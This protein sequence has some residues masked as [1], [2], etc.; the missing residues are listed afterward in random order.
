MFKDRFYIFYPTILMS[1]FPLW[2]SLIRDYQRA[3]LSS[4]AGVPFIYGQ[5]D[6]HGVNYC[7][8]AV[9]FPHNIGLGAAND[10]DRDAKLEDFAFI[11]EK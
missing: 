10:G 8:G 2:K 5:D 1:F 4:E 3:A 11:M 7:R 9:L 6:V